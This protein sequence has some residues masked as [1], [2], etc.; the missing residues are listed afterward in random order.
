[1]RRDLR[2]EDG[3]AAVELVALTLVL[4]VPLLYLVVSVSRVQAGAYAAEAAAYSAARAAV[5][6]GLDSL[7]SGATPESALAQSRAAADAAA[8]VT[9]EDF[10]IASAEVELGC[11]GTCLAAG[12]TVMARVEVHVPLPGLPALIRAAIPAR[13]TLDSTASGPV[14]G[15]AP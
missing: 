15:Y 1:M 4:L 14:D 6:A 11:D 3:A 2:A 7:D 13:I 5:V 8:A 12:S 10:G 9:A